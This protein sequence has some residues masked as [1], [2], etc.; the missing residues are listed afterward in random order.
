M[1]PRLRNRFDIQDEEPLGPLANLVD[2]VLVFA[3][4]LIAVLAARPE[5]MEQLVQRK[6]PQRIERGREL[7]EL[8]SELQAGGSGYES[9]GRVYRDPKTGKLLLIGEPVGHPPDPG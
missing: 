8:P 1:H 5:L 6:Q 2:V 4:G 3:V 9:V 7:P